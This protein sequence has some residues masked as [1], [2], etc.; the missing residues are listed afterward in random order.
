MHVPAGKKLRPAGYDGC[1]AGHVVELK[2][3]LHSIGIPEFIIINRPNRR[4]HP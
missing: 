4:V 2:G 1:L 3:K